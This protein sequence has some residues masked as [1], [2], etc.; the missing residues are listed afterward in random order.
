ML[1]LPAA[2]LIKRRIP[3]AVVHFLT[4]PYTAPLAAMAPDV[5]AVILDESQ[6]AWGLSRRLAAGDYD[7][8]VL[9]HPTAR[10]AGALLLAGI[11]TRA[12]TAYRAYSFLLNR[13]IPLHRKDSL[14]HELELNL[15]VVRRGLGLD[16]DASGEQAFLPRI[17]VSSE[18]RVAAGSLLSSDSSRLVVVHPGSGG[19]ARDWPLSYFAGLMDRLSSQGFDLAVT[20]GPGEDGLRQTIEPMLASRVRWVSGLDLGQLAAILSM[21]KLVVSNSTGPLHIAVAVGARALGI[22]CPVKPCLPR[23]WGPYGPGHAALVPEVPV[24]ER[25]IGPVCP[26]WDCMESLT[27][28]KVLSQALEMLNQKW[29]PN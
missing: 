4:Q 10:L 21:A 11:P 16:G 24:C 19:S 27:V 14:S 18:Q 29:S 26:H 6:G 13:R 28:D 20:L 3:G 5:D 8:A 7:T 25:C 9:L 12:G 15:E 1:S 23:R 2:S 17:T 22:Y